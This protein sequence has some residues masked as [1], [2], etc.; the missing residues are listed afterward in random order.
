MRTQT[1]REIKKK[2]APEKTSIYKELYEKSVQ[3]AES[4]YGASR[5]FSVQFNE[6]GTGRFICENF[7]NKWTHSDMRF[8]NAEEF[9]MKLKAMLK[10]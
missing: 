5:K 8:Q 6:D 3:F 2:F 10:L 1:L 4:I 7:Q 9:E